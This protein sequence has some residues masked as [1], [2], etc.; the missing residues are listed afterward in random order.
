MKK[1]ISLFTGAGG[2]DLGLE[3]AGFQ[4]AAAVEMNDEAV[5]TLRQNR[6][7]NV[8]H[9]NIHDELASNG[10][11]LKAAAV[12]KGEASLLAGGPPCQP[13]SK[14]G[15]WHSGEAK[16]LNDPRAKTLHA[17][18]R[19][20]EGTLP[21]VFLLENVPGLAFNQKDEGL[22]FLRGEIERINT[23]HGTSYS[24]SA[25]QLNAVQF[26]VPQ[27]RERVFIVGHREGRA[28]RFPK[29]THGKPAPTDMANGGKQRPMKFGH[30]VEAPR[31]AWD[32]IGHLQDDPDPQLLPRG[33]WAAL[34]P[35]IPEGQNYLF[36]TNRGGGLPL[37][38][39]RSRYWSMLLKIAKSR[40]SWTITAQPGPAIGP[41]HWKSR[42]LSAAE[43]CALQTFPADYHVVGDVM[44][45]HRQ[46][47]NAV[48]AALAEMLGLAIQQQFFGQ[49]QA[50]PKRLSLLPIPNGSPPAAETVPPV[51]KPE[52]LEIVGAHADHPGTGKGPGATK[53][54]TAG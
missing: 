29:A 31:T 47:G 35:T 5:K 53:R 8:I 51:T 10:N 49:A 28:F 3:A 36:H 7:W 13:F 17:Y 23:K 37:F 48:P 12:G 42:R 19:V 39:W 15:F 44:A 16:R 4:T 27:T 52:Y 1:I 30:D 20:L 18:I 21:E 45:A 54:S 14:S 38:G 40:P 24:F 26:G 2:L 9:S 50:D 33:K 34:L 32:A 22:N 46:L 41:F 11:I 6:D 25:K 43:L